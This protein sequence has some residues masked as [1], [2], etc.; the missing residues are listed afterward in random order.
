MGN[1][2]T[3]AGTLIAEKNITVQ[4]GSIDIGTV[5]VAGNLHVKSRAFLNMQEEWSSLSVGGDLKI[6][7]GNGYGSWLGKG[8]LTLAGDL[9]QT[10]KSD[11]YCMRSMAADIILTGEKEQTIQLKNPIGTKLYH[12]DLTGCEGVKFTEGALSVGW[13]KGFDKIRN[14]ALSLFDSRI[15]LE[16]DETYH[17]E[18]ICYGEMIDCNGYRFIVKGN[19]NWKISFR[20]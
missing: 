7:S 3:S 13:L 4:D 1:A 6:S 9:I 18:L 20:V 15:T 11:S 12:L 10:K 2:D 5:R 19:L 8:T 14:E 17:G 16:Q